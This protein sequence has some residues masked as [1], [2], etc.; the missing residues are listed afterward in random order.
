[1]PVSAEESEEIDKHRALV[2]DTAILTQS[3]SY[4]KW[5]FGSTTTVTTLSALY[6]A[7]GMGNLRLAGLVVFALGLLSMGSAM[8]Y[9]VLALA[10]VWPGDVALSSPEA[11]RKS[12][13]KVIDA[14]RPLVR[15]AGILLAIALFLVALAP[16]ASNFSL[17]REISRPT[18]R[19]AF[20]TA[21]NSVRLEVHG[22]NLARGTRMRLWL[23]ATDGTHW[24]D[25]GTDADARARLRPIASGCQFHLAPTFSP[26]GHRQE[27]LHLLSAIRSMCEALLLKRRQRPRHR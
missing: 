8:A 11:L 18:L 5:V 27:M 23:A 25:M 9:A 10:P 21:P 26:F 2:S 17:W 16:L 20:D 12:V 15:R 24:L 6:T 19:V 3:D 13:R 14:R 4:A 22:S 7:T 1:M